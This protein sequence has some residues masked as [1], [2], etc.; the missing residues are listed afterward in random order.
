MQADAHE[1]DP[2]TKFDFVILSDLVNDLWDVQSVLQNIRSFTTPKSRI[3]IT[4]YSRLWEL[5]FLVFRK[6]RLAKPALFQNWLTVEDIEG[7]LSLA[8][9]EVIRHW[10]EMIWPMR[11]PVIDSLL[12]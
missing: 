6:L 5:P 11:T 1:L 7:L 2:K 8:D 10:D 3:I 4:S 9:F 12:N